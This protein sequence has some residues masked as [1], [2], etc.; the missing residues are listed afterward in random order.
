MTFN[1][2]SAAALAWFTAA[3]LIALSSGVG[4]L[5]VWFVVAVFAIGPAALM[6]H[7]GRAVARTT[8]QAIAEAR[9]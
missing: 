2:V 8:S 4:S 9:R 6:L 3:M 7:F 5:G 1:K